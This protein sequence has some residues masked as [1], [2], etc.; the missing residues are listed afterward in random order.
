MTYFILK[1]GFATYSLYTVK[2]NQKVNIFLSPVIVIL[3]VINIK[4]KKY[5][6]KKTKN[7]GPT[8]LTRIHTADGSF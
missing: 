4:T 3:L 5:S 7:T 1:G 6:E 8:S 2:N